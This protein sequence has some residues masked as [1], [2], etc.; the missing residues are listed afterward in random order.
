MA[1]EVVSL[2]DQV[3]G[4]FDK[5]GVNHWAIASCVHVAELWA[6]TATDLD[7][8]TA[9]TRGDAADMWSSA[10]WRTMAHWLVD[11]PNATG[12]EA[13]AQWDVIC[14]RPKGEPFRFIGGL[15]LCEV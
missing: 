13:D 5:Y 10:C 14:S 12:A 15:I 1:S 7:A 9:A 2:V 8:E 6:G 11:H 4:D 3:N